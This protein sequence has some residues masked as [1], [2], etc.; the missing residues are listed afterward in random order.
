MKDDEARLQRWWKSLSDKQ[1][2]DALQSLQSGVLSEDLLTRLKAEGVKGQRSS[3]ST[4][5]RQVQGFLKT[6]LD[7]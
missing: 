5:T 2:A 6:R 4:M 7:P 3:S 1:R